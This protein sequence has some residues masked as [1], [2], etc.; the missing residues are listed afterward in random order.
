MSEH[1]LGANA[2]SLPSRRS[3]LGT[4]AS[5]AAGAALAAVPAVAS[6]PTD[7]DDL[8][9]LRRAWLNFCHAADRVTGGEWTVMAAEGTEGEYFLNFCK[10]EP[11]P[12][13]IE[14]RLFSRYRRI[15]V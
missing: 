4:A 5:A 1:T 14:P 12:V 10:Y 7:G 9:A 2:P 3:F 11:L 6:P 15:P 13:E 8:A